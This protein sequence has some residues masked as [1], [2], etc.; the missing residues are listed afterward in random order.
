MAATSDLPTLREID[1]A[2]G[3]KSDHPD[4]VPG[5]LYVV[6]IYGAWH[7]GR[8]A[9]VWYGLNFSPWGC[10]GIQFSAP[11]YNLSAWERII[12]FQPKGPTQ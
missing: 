2:R 10:S 11:G 4:I 9:R 3:D 7:M 1:L 12:E 6:K 8:F 5:Q